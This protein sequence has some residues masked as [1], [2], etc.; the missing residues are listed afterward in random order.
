MSEPSG[1]LRTVPPLRHDPPRSRPPGPGSVYRRKGSAGPFVEAEETSTK[2]PARKR[3]VP[4]AA[5][6]GRHWQ[7]AWS[8]VARA[9]G[10]DADAPFDVMLVAALCVLLCL[11]LVAVY[12]SSTVYAERNGG[13]PYSFLAAQAQWMGL[14]LV[15]LGCAARTP[16]AWLRGKAAACYLVTCALLAVVLVPGIGRF[17]G[18]ARRWLAVGPI[19]FQPS[20]VAKLSMVLVLASLFAKGG[21]ARGGVRNV[22]VPVL[23]CQLPVALIV[24]EPDLG[25]AIVIEL[26]LGAML[27]ASGLRARVL[28]LLSLAA[29]PM[30]YHLVVGTPFRLRRVLGYIDPWAFRSTIGY[31]VTEALISIG[32][33]GLWGVGLGDGKQKLFF[34]PEA[35]TDFI[36][37][38]LAEELGLAGVIV[39]LCAFATLIVRG[40]Q[41]AVRSSTP[42]D[43]Y[44]ALGLTCLVGVPAT[45]NMS[46]ATGLLPTKGLPLPLISYGG[47]N[48]LVT[49]M[50]IGCLL[51]IDRSVR[52]D[53]RR[54]AQNVARRDAQPTPRR[55]GQ[56]DAW[57]DARERGR[58]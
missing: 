36:F 6:V 56:P 22:A 21:G 18:G 37:A 30:L 15:A 29:L 42:F 13:R 47:S 17:V 28:G 38:I 23:L 8:A 34:L 31:Q 3:R 7:R 24:V 44:F 5:R 52:R 33:G 49:L 55:E 43:R 40:A 26:I 57:P 54:D 35:H 53:L 12:S 14:G 39:L 50:G 16:G 25:T 46:V 11:G 41:L 20:E 27:F 4:W 10:L 45:L 1:P 19:A 2:S 51:R 48:L 9:T 58:P 32:S